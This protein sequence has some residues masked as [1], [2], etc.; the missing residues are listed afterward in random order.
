MNKKTLTILIVLVVVL[1]VAIAISW[2]LAFKKT[3][4]NQNPSSQNIQTQNTQNPNQEQPK[5]NQATP[6][7]QTL[8]GTLTE[9]DIAFVKIVLDDG[10]E[11][12]FNVVAEA[13]PVFL[14]IDHGSNQPTTDQENEIFYTEVG[15]FD[16]PLGSRVVVEYESNTQNLK[17]IV[18][19][20]EPDQVE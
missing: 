17:K 18:V 3:N 7:I 1:V 12:T 5:L 8:E 11:H 6:S 9:A 13:Q 20:E 2:K 10:S 15:L 14:G 4:P 16:I 19:Q